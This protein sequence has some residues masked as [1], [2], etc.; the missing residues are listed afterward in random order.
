ME[1]GRWRE[2]RPLKANLSVTG[3]FADLSF[4]G[5]SPDDLLPRWRM[6]FIRVVIHT[7]ALAMYCANRCTRSADEKCVCQGAILPR[8]LYSSHTDWE[9]PLAIS[10]IR[11]PQRDSRP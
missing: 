5:Q 2:D 11:R 8:S 9:A 4:A 6:I 7:I 3:R 10:V 1:M